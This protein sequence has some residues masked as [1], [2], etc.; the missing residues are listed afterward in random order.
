MT[1][2]IFRRYKMKSNRI[3]AVA[4][5]AGLVL[6]GGVSIAHAETGY[7]TEAEAKA[8]AEKSITKEEKEYKSYTV[9][10]GVDGKF[11]FNITEKADPLEAPKEKES[12]NRFDQHDIGNNEVG[13]VKREFAEQEAKWVLK[14]DKV[15]K[16]YEIVQTAN[17]RWSYVLSPFE[18]KKPEEKKPEEK[19]EEKGTPEVHTKPEYKLPENKPEVKPSTPDT[20]PSTPA[21]NDKEVDKLIKD[22]GESEKKINDLLEQNEKENAELNKK[23]KKEKDKKEADKKDKKKQAPAKKGNN[24]KTGVVGLGSVASL[25]AISMAGIVATRKRK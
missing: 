2:W 25:A 14:N 18:N 19:K 16:S 9:M 12:S 23:D 24:P 3:L 7:A 1:I 8:A 22:L 11:Y 20:K 4:L 10:K 17:G 13:F 6:A 15:N 5:S 21:E